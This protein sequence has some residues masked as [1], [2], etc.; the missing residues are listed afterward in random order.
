[1]SMDWESILLIAG[2]KYTIQ[3]SKHTHI[4]NIIYIYKYFLLPYLCIVLLYS[5]ITFDSACSFG[6]EGKINN[7]LQV[8]VIN[9]KIFAQYCH[10]FLQLGKCIVF[11]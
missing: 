9:G 11:V 3:N 10:D 2:S 1:M 4:I 8:E 5:K 6:E 7:R